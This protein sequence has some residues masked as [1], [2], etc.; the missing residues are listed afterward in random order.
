LSET[1]IL[2]SMPLVAALIGYST[3]RL[4]IWMIFEPQEFRG[5]GPLGWQGI[6]PRN[7]AKIGS[8]AM[9]AMFN[10]LLTPADLLDRIDPETTVAAVEQPLSEAL[11]DTAHEIAIRFYPGLWERVPPAARRAVLARVRRRAPEMMRHLLD[12]MRGNVDGLFDLRFLVVSNLVRNKSSLNRLMREMVTP[13]LDFIRRSGIVFG[14]CI[15]LVQMTVWAT[16][17]NEWVIP[18]FGLITGGTTDWLALQM[19]FRPIERK[20]YLGLFRWHGMLHRRRPEITRAY[21]RM[22]AGEL[23][24]PSALME[25][26]LT[27]PPSDRLLVMVGREVQAAIDAELGVTRP[28]VTLVVGDERYREIKRYAA[29]RAVER[30]PA[31]APEIQEHAARTLNTEQLVADRMQ[32]MDAEEYEGIMRPAFKDNEWLVVVLGALLGFAVG[33]TQLLLI[34]HL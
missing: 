19:L 14:F 10:R 22:G 27:G 2:L 18:V 12:D 29:Q 15:G 28:L 31:V 26:I 21:A 30:L 6:V 8:I 33:E 11:E 3:K 32:S 4:L 1:L 16:T 13:E 17:H 5:I 20:R 25:M 23:L 24:H 7:A 34:T 9:A